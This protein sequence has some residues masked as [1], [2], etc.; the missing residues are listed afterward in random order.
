MAPAA[1]CLAVFL[2]E[3]VAQLA[4]GQVAEV[5][6]DL[7]RLAGALETRVLVDA[8]HLVEDDAARRAG[9][10]FRAVGRASAARRRKV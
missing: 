3:H 5:Q 6:L 9:Y 2:C 8:R 4:A 1:I 10:V 7:D